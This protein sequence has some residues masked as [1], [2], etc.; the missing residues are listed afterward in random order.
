MIAIK[1][2][3]AFHFVKSV[4]ELSALCV[5]FCLLLSPSVSQGRESGESVVVVYNRNMKESKEV[6]DYYAQRRSVPADQLIGLDLPTTETMTREEYLQ[7]LQ[8]PLMKALLDAKIW[9]E[10]QVVE[11]GIQQLGKSK[12]RYA[13]L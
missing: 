1:L 2:S 11:N 8:R 13:A 3:T 5:G 10:L 6:A 4:R 9:D 12:I 7:R